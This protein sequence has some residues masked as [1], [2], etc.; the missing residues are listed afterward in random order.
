MNPDIK[1]YEKSYL[2]FASGLKVLFDKSDKDS[3]V[4]KLAHV[5]NLKEFRSLSSTRAFITL[6]L[7]DGI[8]KRPEFSD[9]SGKKINSPSEDSVIQATIFS[10]LYL[11]LLQSVE[12]D[13][14]LKIS[15]VKKNF[16]RNFL[17]WI[18]KKIGQEFYIFLP[19][20]NSEINKLKIDKLIFRQIS[21][22]EKKSLFF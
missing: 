4:E 6:L 10:Y 13:G 11:P 8:I 7:E 17:I 16:R 20:L 2:S 21:D 22:Q 19:G 18:G 5:I 14:K 15:T 3:A 1:K 9:N 12:K